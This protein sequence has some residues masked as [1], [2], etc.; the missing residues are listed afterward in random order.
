VLHP[1]L[2]EVV[3]TNTSPQQAGV[4]FKV[5]MFDVPAA[6]LYTHIHCTS[7]SAGIPNA[8]AAT[9]AT[10]CHIFKQQGL[11]R[12]SHKYSSSKK[13][14]PANG[15]LSNRVIPPLLQQNYLKH[16]SKQSCGL[17]H[18]NFAPSRTRLNNK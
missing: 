1:I 14:V 17:N 16:H 18:F 2:L 9:S 15:C 8:F 7:V 13:F 5:K 11:S 3:T 12:F 4:T 6:G 10:H